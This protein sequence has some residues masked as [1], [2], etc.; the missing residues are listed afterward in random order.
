[1]TKERRQ[2]ISMRAEFPIHALLE[3]TIEALAGL[4][5]ESI[6]SL[7]GECPLAV[8]PGSA[9][10]WR[11]AGPPGTGPPARRDRRSNRDAAPGCGSGD[12]VSHVFDGKGNGSRGGFERRASVARQGAASLIDA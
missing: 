3:R 12:A 2:A 8:A 11:R 10:E 6:E 1:M 5:A 9:E 7:V 4:D